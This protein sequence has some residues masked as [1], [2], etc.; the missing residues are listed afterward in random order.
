LTSIAFSGVIFGLSVISLPAISTLFGYGAVV[1]GLIAA[2]IYAWHARRVEYPLLDPKLFRNRNFRTAMLGGMFFRVGIGAFPFLMPLMLQLVFGFTPLES[3]LTTFVS[4][5]G[6]ILSK[7]FAERLYARLGFPRTLT[8]TSAIGCVFLAVNGLFSP[9]TNH[10]LLMFCLFVGGLTRSFFFTG[11]NVFGY[12]DVDEAEASQATA[13]AAVM[14][15]I[16]VALGVAIAGG[17]L[18]ATT[19]IRG[20]PLDLTSFHI[21]WY[22]V[23]VLAAIS[24]FSFFRLPPDAGSNVSGHRVKPLPKAEAVA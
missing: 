4:A 13:I 10:Y 23:A 20:V 17:I 16:S 5:F 22:I 12:A 19:L 15:Q 8:I 21:A 2:A 3:G 1:I 14:Q 9:E 24:A 11:I 18:E 6:A 7:F